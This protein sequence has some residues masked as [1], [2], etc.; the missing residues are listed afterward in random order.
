MTATIEVFAD[1][2]CPFTHVGL[3]VIAAEVE[4][5]NQAVDIRVRAWPL[6]WVNGSSLDVDGVALK[7]A[8]LEAQLDVD[9]FRGFRRDRWPHTTL[10]ALNL[11][12]AAYQRDPATGFAVSLLLRRLLFEEGQDISDQQVL[13]EVA[14][15][16]A[17]PMP[18]MEASDGVQADYAEGKRRGVRGSPDFWI[19]GREFFC[20]SLDIGHD[21]DGNLTAEF[22]DAGI[23]EI[24]RNLS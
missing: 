19:E 14:N 4:T 20:P 12:D 21:P 7:V 5:L 8:A 1:I 3:K 2:N 18:P 16:F 11:V 6:E 9:D 22:D 17:L 13:A 15:E 23:R 24:V 10:S